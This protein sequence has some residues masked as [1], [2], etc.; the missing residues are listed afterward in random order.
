MKSLIMFGSALFALVLAVLML[1]GA[2]IAAAMGEL[3]ELPRR[4]FGISNK[5]HRGDMR[6]EGGLCV[7]ELGGYGYMRSGRPIPCIAGGDGSA[8]PTVEEFLSAMGS[9]FPSLALAPKDDDDDKP[10]EHQYPD[11]ATLGL[12][13][14]ADAQDNALKPDSVLVQ[15]DGKWITATPDSI[16]DGIHDARMERG[17]LG[18]IETPINRATRQFNVDVGSVLV[19]G[20]SG[21]VLGE[22]IDGFVSPQS[23]TGGVNF[24]NVLAK[25][26]G[27]AGFTMFGKQLM[28]PA[29]VAAG[30]TILS[31]QVLADILPLDRLVGNIVG[32]FQGI[33]GGNMA[34]RQAN[35]IIR[36]PMSQG[37]GIVSPGSDVLGAT[38]SPQ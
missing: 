32:F 35:E 20:V 17:L 25:G 26:I 28:S 38:L 7:N 5:S 31:L 36:R 4:S 21:L 34:L 1:I 37:P 16:Y 12:A 6:I 9:K 22:V 3:R 27:I 11:A 29:G 23:D 19:G 33:G 24:A 13:T 14:W 15:Q 2:G 30:V 8:A 10:K 18:A